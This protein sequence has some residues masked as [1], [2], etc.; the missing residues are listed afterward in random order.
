MSALNLVWRIEP[1]PGGKAMFFME[2]P[3][4]TDHGRG[5]A[6]CARSLWS[7]PAQH[8]MWQWDGNFQQPTITPSIDC[9]GGC[10]RHFTMTKGVPQ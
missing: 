3:L 8:P 4:G 2:C 6:E 9:K 10:G 1:R 5:V 7:L